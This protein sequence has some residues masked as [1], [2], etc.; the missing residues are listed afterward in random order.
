[1]K[2]RVFVTLEAV[3]LRSAGPHDCRSAALARLRRR[4]RRA[5]GQVLRAR[6]RRAASPAEAE[7]LAAEVADRVL[8]NPVIESFR[9]EIADARRMRGRGATMTFAVVVFPGSNCDHDAYHAVKHVLGQQAAVRLAQG[10]VARRR[11]RR[12]P[13]RRVLARRLP[14][15]GRDRAVLADHGRGQGVRRGRRPGARHLQRFS[16]SARVRPAAGR[17]AAQSRRQVPLRVRRRARR[18][19]G[20]AVHG[21]CARRARCCGCRSRTA[22]AT[23]TRRR[24]CSTSSRRTGRVVFRYANAAGETDRCRPIRTARSTASPASATTAATSSA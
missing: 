7:R 1:M 5:A 8:A 12:H 19:D 17:D 4:R 15:H 14:A 24:T 18:A 13:A 23:T 9:M 3:G 22:R 16:D 10:D 6:S 21:R 11:R 2:A 20:H